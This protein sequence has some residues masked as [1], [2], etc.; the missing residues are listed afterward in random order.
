MTLPFAYL[1]DRIIPTA[2]SNINVT[3]LSIQRGYGIF[4]YFCYHNGLNTHLD[5]YFDRLYTSIQLANL[6]ITTNRSELKAIIDELY[7]KN[8]VVKANMKVIV[9]AGYSS[10]GYNPAQSANLIILSYPHKDNPQT[11]YSSGVKLITHDYQRPWPEIKSINYFCSALLAPRMKLENAID[12]LY[13]SNNYV[14]ETS[15]ANIFMVKNGEI[16]TPASQILKG[17]TRGKIV[18]NTQGLKVTQREITRAELLDADEVFITSTTKLVMPVIQ[19][20]NTP[21]RL[22]KVGPITQKLLGALV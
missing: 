19:I 7:H 13:I 11:N 1:N 15:R 9:T 16:S 3:D 4:D 12:V 2:E 14:R 10:D 17:I 21:I 22:S 20:D 18:D 5:Q 6:S 8:N